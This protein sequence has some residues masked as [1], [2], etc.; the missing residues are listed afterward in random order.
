MIN[1]NSLAV[2]NCPLSQQSYW[3]EKDGNDLSEKHYQRVC[4]NFNCCKLTANYN[5]RWYYRLITCTIGLVF[6]GVLLAGGSLQHSSENSISKS[7]TYRI[8]Q[9]LALVF[10]IVLIVVTI[11]LIY[12]LID[13]LTLQKDTNETINAK[14]LKYSNLTDLFH[15]PNDFKPELRDCSLIRNHLPIEGLPIK[16]DLKNC[17]GSSCSK[18]VMRAG[19]SVPLAQARLIF[20]NGA[21]VA[22]VRIYPSKEASQFFGDLGAQTSQVLLEGQP[23]RIMNLINEELSYCPAEGFKSQGALNVRLY[24]YT[25][26]V[27]KKSSNKRINAI[28]EGDRENSSVRYHRVSLENRAEEKGILAKSHQTDA[29]SAV[30]MRKYERNFISMVGGHWGS[31]EFQ[32]LDA[33]NGSEIGGV[34]IYVYRGSR[35]CIQESSGEFATLGETN[36]TGQFVAYNL[37]YGNYT[38]QFHSK[39]RLLTAL[40]KK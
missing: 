16:Y 26:D 38:V 24:Q 34:E 9:I 1:E 3:W 15:N 7:D 19:L 5:L 36:S 13:P 2:P 22:N 39:G 27:V 37:H 11:D 17:S 35:A 6:F 25:P 10:F 20:K 29:E 8:Y 28:T 31:F 18:L 40:K 14:D 33:I 4:L 32:L 12:L 23:D 21:N 30:F